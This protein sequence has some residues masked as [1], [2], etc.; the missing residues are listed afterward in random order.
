LSAVTG[1][2]NTAVLLTSSLTMALA[3]HAARL[4]RRHGVQLYLAA[5]FLLGSTFLVIKACEWYSEYSEALVP[6]LRF[7]A[8]K[9]REKVDEAFS[10]KDTEWINLG[11][12]D[13]AQIARAYSD[14][15]VAS[16]QMFYVFYFIITGLH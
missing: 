9:W 12:Q 2:I 6:R 14:R 8:S 7:D 5:T 1:A 10:K 4:G 3:V 15:F 16:V 11:G 13:R